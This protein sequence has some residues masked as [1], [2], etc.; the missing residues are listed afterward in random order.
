MSNGHTGAGEAR[1]RK[2]DPPKLTGNPMP[3]C[4]DGAIRCAVLSRK[5]SAIM[6]GGKYMKVT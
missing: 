5:W 2:D 4:W 6:V 1:P 3:V